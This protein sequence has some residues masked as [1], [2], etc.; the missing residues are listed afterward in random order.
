MINIGTHGS[1]KMCNKTILMNCSLELA[2]DVGVFCGDAGGLQDGDP[3]GKDITN[4]QVLKC[5]KWSVQTGLQRSLHL[6]CTSWEERRNKKPNSLMSAYKV[7]G[8]VELIVSTLGCFQA[9]WTTA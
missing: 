4:P 9:P 3:E 8:Q 6:I 1:K 7:A 2:E 5:V